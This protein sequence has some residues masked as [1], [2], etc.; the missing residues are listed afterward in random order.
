MATLRKYENYQDYVDFQKQKTTDPDRR[1]KWLNEEWDLKLN[2]FIQ[3]FKKLESFI[4]PETD[5]LCLG[6]RTGQEVVALKKLGVKNVIGIDIVP[7]EPHVILGDIHDLDFEDSSFDFVYTNIMDHSIDPKKMVQEI[8]RVL[9]V[10]GLVFIQ[11][12]LGVHQDEY[13]EFEI[14]DPFHDVV[15]L[16]DRSYCVHIGPIKSDFS[17]NFSAMNFE[18]VFQKDKN[19]D[20]VFRDIGSVSS[21]N[22]PQEYQEIWEEVNLEIQKNKLS[23]NNILDQEERESIL[24]GL[25][26][27][28]FFLVSLAKE[29]EASGIAEVGTA[30]GWQF[31]SFCEYASKF[32]GKV[33]TCDPR[34]VRNDKMRSKYE[35]NLGVGDYTQGTSTEMANKCLKSIDMFYVDGLHDKGDVIRDVGNLMKCQKEEKNS[36]W[37]F[38]DFDARFGCYDDISRLCQMSRRFKV[39][40]VGKTASGNNNHQAIL[41]VK[42]S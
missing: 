9:R 38:D 41:H 24:N 8:E 11:I 25:S 7:Q 35:D 21:L 33:Y 34:D 15:A 26:K 16:F 3:E 36:V 31:Y 28:S 1:K 19:L 27:R 20:N 14:K 4:G 32:S 13:T 30:Q 2:G 12:Q 22:V 23:E 39:I 18:M 17:T 5:A 6:A 10:G 29:Y 37:I 42:F 40:N